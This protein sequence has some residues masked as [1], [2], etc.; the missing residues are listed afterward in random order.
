ML[1]IFSNT[2]FVKKA[3]EIVNNSN[4]DFGIK[5][6]FGSAK[7]LFVVA[8]SKLLNKKIL[9]IVPNS[10]VYTDFSWSKLFAEAETVSL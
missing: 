3:S 8:L 10:E 1:K 7:S 2:N 6:L 4:D 5:I 9:L